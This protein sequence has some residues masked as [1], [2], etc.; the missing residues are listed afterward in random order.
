MIQVS[1]KCY[2]ATKLTFLLQSNE[3][4]HIPVAI[5]YIS[6]G[7]CYAATNDQELCASAVQVWFCG[8]LR[9]DNSF[10]IGI[11]S[12][13]ELRKN[14]NGLYVMFKSILSQSV[15]ERMNHLCSNDAIQQFEHKYYEEYIG[16]CNYCDIKI[17]EK[18]CA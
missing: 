9:K 14:L 5:K 2:A 18:W 8:S 6:L 10:A 7:K 3:E 17:L 11:V 4:F 1:I 12:V 16:K 13:D 15:E